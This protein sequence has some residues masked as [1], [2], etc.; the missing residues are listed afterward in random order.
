MQQLR[1]FTLGAVLALVLLVGL[2]GT[3]MAFT[4]YNN[5]DY[6]R[7]SFNPADDLLDA[8]R[9]SNVSGS[10]AA[11]GVRGLGGGIEYSIDAGF[12]SRLIP[13]FIDS[14]RPSCAQLK[15]AIKRAFKQWSAGNPFLKF[16]DTSG[17]IIAMLPPKGSTRPLDGYGAEINFFALSEQEFPD[18]KGV[19]ASTVLS[20][21]SPD[22]I[23]TNG[24]VLS[25]NTLTSVDIVFNTTPF[26]CFHLDPAL[27]DRDCNDFESLVLHE[28]GHAI[29]LGHP[30][31]FPGHNFDSDGDP[32]NVIPID[33]QDPTK[34][35]KLSRNIDPKAVMNSSLGGKPGLVLVGLTNDDLGGRN[36]LYPICSSNDT[37]AAPAG[38]SKSP[39]NS[40]AWMIALG[41]MLFSLVVRRQSRL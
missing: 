24:E 35:L 26:N 3:G 27:T 39:L 15:T 9:W 5:M 16:T 38:Q 32:T 4:V 6:Y 12:C 28:I 1:A 23:G 10:L 36:F 30:N 11:D 21:L 22:P 37:A 29:G 19:G 18:V 33:C 41:V 31:Q 17:K 7:T 2:A 25:G 34:G 14:P 8:A 40:S 20:F 13:F